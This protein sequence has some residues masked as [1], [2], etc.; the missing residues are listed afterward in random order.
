MEPVE[1]IHTPCDKCDV[2]GIQGPG[3]TVELYGTPVLFSCY[4]CDTTLP[5][6]VESIPYEHAVIYQDRK[7]Y[8]ADSDN[9]DSIREF[10]DLDTAMEFYNARPTY[11][12]AGTVIIL[13]SPAGQL[14]RFD[15]SYGKEPVCKE[16]AMQA[17]M[18]GGCDAY[19][20]AMGY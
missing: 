5:E 9:C 6:V 3:N 17:G 7:D 1:N 10:D 8:E 19:N 13:D 11:Y 16:Y 15:S 4:G 20:T 12:Y 18:M 2:C 14:V